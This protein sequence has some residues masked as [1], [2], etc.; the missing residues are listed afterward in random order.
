MNKKTIGLVMWILGFICYVFSMSFLAK[1]GDKASLYGFL[2]S[3]SAATFCWG[4][5]LREID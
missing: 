1:L 3:V 4:I 2:A 5:M